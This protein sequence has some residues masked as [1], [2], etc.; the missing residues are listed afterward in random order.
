MGWQVEAGNHEGT[1]LG[2]LIVALAVD[3]PGHL[4]EA[5]WRVA[6]YLHERVGQPGRRARA[7]FSGAAGR[8][9]ARLAT[10]IGEVVW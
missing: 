7:I 1:D 5:P 3:S 4:S 2:G 10:H 8:H 9:P 6:L